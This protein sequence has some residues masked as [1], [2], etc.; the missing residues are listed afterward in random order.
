[1]I[2]PRPMKMQLWMGDFRELLVRQHLGGVHSML[3][4]AEGGL[5]KLRDCWHCASAG[6]TRISRSEGFAG[7]L[8]IQSCW[9]DSNW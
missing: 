4:R 6:M 5:L 9:G 7:S 1:M 2:L 3:Q 8:A